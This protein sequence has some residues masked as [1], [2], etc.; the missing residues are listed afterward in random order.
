MRLFGSL[1]TAEFEAMLERTAGKGSDALNRIS[2]REARRIIRK[3]KRPSM[4]TRPRRLQFR[5]L[6]ENVRSSTP[7]RP[8]G[9]AARGAA[10]AGYVP[11]SSARRPLDDA[12]LYGEQACLL[13][14]D[15]FALGSATGGPAPISDAARG[16]TRLVGNAAAE[17]R[18]LHPAV[19]AIY[20]Q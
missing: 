13:L 5:R 20:C 11:L 14:G 18:H 2:K 12:K 15:Q 1:T 6:I 4:E 17:A 3:R 7:R 19:E 10:R 9:A 16:D 8:L